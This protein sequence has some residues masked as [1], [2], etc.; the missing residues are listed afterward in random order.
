VEQDSYVSPLQN[1]RIAV[2][3]VSAAMKHSPFVTILKLCCDSATKAP[4]RQVRALLH[5]FASTSYLFQTETLA[6]PLDALLESLSIVT[7]E[8]YLDAILSLLD[9]VVGRCIRTPFKYLDDYAELASEIQKT[10]SGSTDLAPVS[11]II[12]TLVEQWKFFMQ[13]KDTLETKLAGADWLSRFL[14]SCALVGENRYVLAV[15]CDRLVSCAPDGQSRSIFSISRQ[16]FQEDMSPKLCNR[17]VED[18]DVVGIRDLFTTSRDI[19]IAIIPLLL[20]RVQ[21]RRVETSLFDLTVVQR[22][23][24]E[25]VNTESIISS[26]ATAAVW[27]LCELLRYIAFQLV[28]QNEAMAAKTKSFV[29]REGVVIRLVLDVSP[30]KDKISS[31]I[32]LFHGEFTPAQRGSKNYSG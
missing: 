17:A 18:S 20:D 8:N 5:S 2:H 25:V 13:G 23:I 22:A 24:M 28:G 19:D 26:D 9:E 29:A 6:S 12:M 27:S 1:P 11:P 10:T 32:E 14:D 21:H 30:S 3:V 7:I 4:L 16:Y 15:L 31:V